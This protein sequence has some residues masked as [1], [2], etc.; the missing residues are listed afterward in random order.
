M[1]RGEL[2]KGTYFTCEYF[3][4]KYMLIWECISDIYIDISIDTSILY[5]FFANTYRCFGLRLK[6]PLQ[7]LHDSNAAIT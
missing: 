7:T 4:Y 1:G 5:S 3:D 2:T 6:L